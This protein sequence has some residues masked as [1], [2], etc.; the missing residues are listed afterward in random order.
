MALTR[1]Y[2]RYDADTILY[3]DYGEFFSTPLRSGIHAVP[4]HG[5]LLEL[6]VHD[7]GASTTL[8]LFHAAVDLSAFTLPVFTGVNLGAELEAN[9]VFISDPCLDLGISTTWF[10]G[11][12]KRPLQKDL[13]DILAHVQ[14]EL[15]ARHLMFYGASAGGFASMFYS[16]AFPGSLAIASN[17]QTNIADFYPEHVTAYENAAWD[18]ALAEAAAVTNLCGLY[19]ESFPNTVIYLQNTCDAMHVEN[20][21]RPWD[22]RVR[23][24]QEVGGRLAYCLDDWD[25]GHQPPPFFLVE[26]ILKSAVAVEGDWKRLLEDDVFT[27]APSVAS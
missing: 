24:Q 25:E 8:V 14:K 5:S 22:A 9:L 16:H 12:Q 2:S 3:T 10:T 21:M 1:N 26:A 15:G 4:Y 20:H 11:D 6:W 19:E 13:V 27:P 23:T 7:R 18:G 17:P